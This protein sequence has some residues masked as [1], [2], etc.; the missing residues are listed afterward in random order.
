MQTLKKNGKNPPM[1]GY[2]P[3][4]NGVSVDGEP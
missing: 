1:P 2:K 4:E 3:A